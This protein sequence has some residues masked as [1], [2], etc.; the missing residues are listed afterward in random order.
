ML[1][2]TDSAMMSR[3]VLNSV[4]CRRMVFSK[5]KH[6]AFSGLPSWSSS[7]ASASKTTDR[8]VSPIGVSPK[9]KMGAGATGGAAGSSILKETLAAA[10]EVLPL[11]HGE[12]LHGF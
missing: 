8:S 3:T 12:L 7:D 9:M 6:D 11:L 1:R 4:R 2:S 10:F 5:R